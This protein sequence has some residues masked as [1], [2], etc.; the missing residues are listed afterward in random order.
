MAVLKL[1]PANPTPLMKDIPTTL[2][3]AVALL[4]ITSAIQAANPVEGTV[5]P[6]TL[7]TIEW[8]GTAVGTGG[9]DE[10]STIEGVNRDTFVLHVAAGDYTGKTIAVKVAWTSPGNDYD[11][12]I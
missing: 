8:D 12:Y 3:I 4:T 6:A 9:T 10:T 7:T 5:T 1:K 11:L 2:I